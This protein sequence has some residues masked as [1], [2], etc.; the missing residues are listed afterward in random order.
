MQAKWNLILTHDTRL[1]GMQLYLQ[2]LART[3]SS[4]PMYGGDV[5]NRKRFDNSL[6]ILEIVCVS[7]AEPEMLLNAILFK[8]G[9]ELQSCLITV[10]VVDQCSEV[11]A[12]S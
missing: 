9:D 7:G 12:K 5:D 8:F 11:I 3:E 4:R 2:L 1:T 10:L 6:Y